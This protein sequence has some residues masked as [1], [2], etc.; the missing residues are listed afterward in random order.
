[1]IT[2]SDIFDNLTYGELGH[3]SIGNAP[4][5]FIDPKDY[6]KIVS[7]V[8]N[9]LT[10]LHKRFLLR[11]EEVRVQERSNINTYYMRIGH[12]VSNTADITSTKYILD[13]TANPFSGSL[14]KIEGIISDTTGPFILND[15]SQDNPVYTPNFDTFVI[16]PTDPPEILTVKLRAD[17]PRI[18][19]ETGFDPALVQLHIPYSILD[20]ISLN[21]AARIYSPLTAG[22]GE[23]SAASVFMYRYEMECKRLEEEGMTLESDVADTRFDNKGF[24]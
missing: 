20:A 15:S 21:V 4:V 18:K 17:H 2:L 11:D 13:S 19:L 6:P 23:R 22:D 7:A 14:F 1:M 8:N 3:I 24:V 12:A 10:A 5:G 9:A 16:T